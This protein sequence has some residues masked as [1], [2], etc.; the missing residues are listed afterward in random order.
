MT[1]ISVES[2]HA[3]VHGPAPELAALSQENEKLNDRVIALIKEKTD[4]EITVGSNVREI[5]RLNKLVDE[6]R[7]R[8]AFYREDAAKAHRQHHEDLALIGERLI[9]E[10]VE[11]DWCGEYDSIVD[12]LN[13][14]LHG[15]LPLRYQ[16]MVMVFEVRVPVR[17]RPG[18]EDDAISD[19]RQ[20]IE[21]IDS[22]LTY[23]SEE[24]SVDA[25]FERFAD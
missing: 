19:A 18:D 4:A 2:L 22:R 17:V 12:D 7:D 3:L 9:T 15:E 24:E 8:N 11:R 25:T 10:S 16:E 13:G 20:E 1:D 6:L 14:S 5:E 21:A 23:S